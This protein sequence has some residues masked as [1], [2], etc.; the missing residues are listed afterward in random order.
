MENALASISQ[1]RLGLDGPAFAA[2]FP[3]HF[4]IDSRLNVAQCGPGLRKIEGRALEGEFL[5]LRFE[6]LRPEI[7][8]DFGAMRESKQELFILKSARTGCPFRGQ[9]IDLEPGQTLAFVGSPWVTS[10]EQIEA[11]GLDF[12]D[13]P[14][15][16]PLLDMLQL[17][18]T[19]QMSYADM[20][21]LALELR[22]RQDELEASN[23]ALQKEMRE[24]A[25]TEADLRATSRRL[26]TLIGSLD[27]GIL[28]E[29]E[30]RRIVHA[31]EAFCRMF[32][33]P[34][35]PADLVGGDCSEMAKLSLP[36]LE[37]PQM[38]MVELQ[39]TLAEKKR[40]SNFEIRFKNGRVLKRDYVPIHVGDRYA[41]HLWHYSD[42]TELRRA[43][44]AQFR[45]FD[46]LRGINQ[47]LNEFAYVVSHDLKAPLRGIASLASW[48]QADHGSKLDEEG[49]EHLAMLQGRVQ[50][51]NALIDGVLQYSRAGRLREDT[52][53]LSISELARETLEVLN[54][55]PGIEVA[56]PT[57]LPKLRAER[58]RLFQIFQNLLGN[59]VKHMGR[60]EGKV[61]LLAR[62][63]ATHWQFTVRDN[64]PG[65]E[66][67]HHQ[68]IF[69]LFQTL[70]RNDTADSTGIGLAIVKRNVEMSGGKVWVE[71]A[72]GRGSS[73]HFTLPKTEPAGARENASAA[74]PA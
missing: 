52:V 38:F 48:L 39:R 65:I 62:D 68:R 30:Q 18:Q 4:V 23:L 14:L 71:S 27:G 67:R 31:N 1:P 3:F 12:S 61:E 53:E 17:L 49:R 45:M 6:I 70:G 42:V 60:A 21:R 43:Q 57:D 40:V 13:I 54:I 8:M 64:G 46:E 47:E 10:A 55:P 73:F 19:Q 28:V 72:P 24:R 32:G 34:S 36:L 7:E 15:H 58:T 74:L 59:A 63:A 44:E 9:M 33:I 29:D 51:M 16:D 41:G 69:Q 5:P 20:E 2:L 66:P 26:A 50:R 22:R 37:Q 35:G 11:M 56:I 25:R